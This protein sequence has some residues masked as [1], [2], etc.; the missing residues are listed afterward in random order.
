MPVVVMVS[1][2]TVAQAVVLNSD[3]PVATLEGTGYWVENS[4]NNTML[5]NSSVIGQ[6]FELQ[7]EVKRSETSVAMTISGEN[8]LSSDMTG[9]CNVI[10]A[11]DVHV[12][13]GQIAVSTLSSKVVDSEPKTL[14]QGSEGVVLELQNGT[15][16]SDGKLGRFDLAGSLVVVE[17]D[18]YFARSVDVLKVAPGG[19]VELR[20]MEA[21]AE[22][23]LDMDNATLILDDSTLVVGPGADKDSVSEFVVNNVQG[24]KNVIVLQTGKDT[25]HQLDLAKRPV[26]GGVIKGTGRLENLQLRGGSLQIGQEGG[27]GSLTIKDVVMQKNGT[28]STEWKFNVNAVGDFNYA[29]ANVVGGNNFSQLKVEGHG[30]YA[31][32]VS[33]VLEYQNGTAAA[34][35]KKFERGATI[36]LIDMS[37]GSLS[38][39]CYVDYE[40]LPALGA[41]LAWY[42]YELFLTGDLVVV[43]DYLNNMIIGLIDDDDFTPGTGDDD[44]GGTVDDNGGAGD[45]NGGTGDDN[46]GTGDDNGGT[47]DDNGGTGDDNS[48]TGDDNGGTGDDNGGTG[49]DNGGT[50]DDN[51]GTGDDNGGTGDDNGGTGDDNGG[52]GDDNGGTG[53]DNGGTGDD[54]GG[55]GDD[56]G[57]TGNPGT[58]GIKWT[59]LQK[60]AIRNQERD[61][62]R[63]ANTLVAAASATSSFG[64][65]AMA[66][67]DD[68]RQ[69]K[70]NIWF[71]SYYGTNDC[72]STGTR[73]GYSSDTLGYAV[74][75]DT[76]V[77]RYNAVVGAAFGGSNGSMKPEWGNRYYSAGKIDMDGMQ[78]GVYGRLNAGGGGHFSQSA[79]KVDGFI[80]YG[81][82]EC[83]SMR[84]GR[85]NGDRATGGWDET[86]LA[87]GVTVSREQQWYHEVMFTPFVGFEFTT[88]DMDNLREKGYTVFNYYCE[89]EHR[90]LEVFAGIKAHREFPLQRGQRLVPYL[91]L[92]MGMDIA[93]QYAK[94]VSRSAAGSAAAEAVHPGRCF[95][96]LGVGTEWIISQTWSAGAGCIFEMRK[97]AAE[98]RIEINASYSF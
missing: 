98:Q 72:D 56:N 52:T 24:D 41:G 16:L 34:L 83:K 3:T 33:I 51:G 15:C 70:S 88:A 25:M 84:S 39:N 46:G 76:Y 81:M 36:R 92:T 93:R 40:Q 58:N 30:N 26:V 62:T 14:V 13:A 42:P 61:A 75:M 19:T 11:Q 54:N 35:E 85:K 66:H 5:I 57:G 89:K 95:L 68:V 73:T 22:Y 50:G 71:S 53:D 10:Y 2:M 69:R 49:D 96:E 80:S 94:V 9:A 32:S 79:Y 23:A 82:Y 77:D 60:I 17:S 90:N 45:D 8:F 48:G 97:N 31:Q 12:D 59:D 28:Q 65:A 21:Y 37:A 27:Y 7:Q 87:L 55:T 4:V 74:G 29:G 6:S 86:A 20:D 18:T 43:D 38:G 63:I 1:L 67:V 64:H 78:L 91:S 44:N 47:G